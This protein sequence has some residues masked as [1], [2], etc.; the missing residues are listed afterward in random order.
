MQH[1]L[2]KTE[3]KSDYK[4]PLAFLR[5]G[6]TWVPS[7]SV[8]GRI[9]ESGQHLV[10]HWIQ[11]IDKA[12]QSICFSSFIFQ[13]GGLVEALERAAARGVKI[14]I[15]TST[16]HL[17]QK[18]IYASDEDYKQDVFK[19]LLNSKIRNRMLLRCAN[20]IHAK[21]LLIDPQHNDAKGWLATCNFTLKA[22]LENP[23]LAVA[24]NA[25]EIQELF[26][27]FVWHFWEGTTHE[28][29][30]KEEFAAIEPLKK[31]T[32]PELSHLYV[33]SSKGNQNGLRDYIYKLIEKAQKSITLSTFGLDINHRLG[34]LLLQKCQSGVDVVIFARSREK[35]I[36]EHLKPL[37]AA[38]ATVYTHEL[39]HA[40]F[41]CVDNE[42]A[43]IF[44]ANIEQ[45]GMDEGFE[46]G[47]KL[48]GADFFAIKAI[49][50]RWEA[51]FPYRVRIDVPI[52]AITTYDR[53]D[54]NGRLESIQI[55][56]QIEKKLEI[57]PKN[58]R[59]ILERFEQLCQ[60][61]KKNMQGAQIELSTVLES[62]EQ[63][64]S[65]YTEVATGVQKGTYL[66]KT[67]DGKALEKE[68]IFI[69]KTTTIDALKQTA[70]SY[71][72]LPIF[73]V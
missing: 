27:L 29:T 19:K 8:S 35:V 17:E 43:A 68:A 50:D 3:L 2:F 69:H 6:K 48:A 26:R 13:D 42:E 40:K 23:E 55:Q 31:F 39:L 59:D 16:T 7:S 18:S 36:T 58:I 70:N 46:V 64:L 11:A 9:I 14:F 71:R 73:Y 28:Q 60:F 33:T 67:K 52:S 61:D 20:N 24:L 72:H 10:D 47:V 5:T 44:T 51:S 4:A 30:H 63:K 34:K 1:I 38:G 54:A 41:I 37:L 15:L 53:F 62:I 57:R 12:Q 21:F 22:T 25:R 32:I 65:T 49:I 66:E 45:H 56:K